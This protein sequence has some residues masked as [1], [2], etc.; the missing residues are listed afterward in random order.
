V[1]RGLL[2]PFLFVRPEDDALNSIFRWYCTEAKL[3]SVLQFVGELLD[4]ADHERFLVMTRDPDDDVISLP[5]G[6]LAFVLDTLAFLHDEANPD[7]LLSDMQELQLG[8]ADYLLISEPTDAELADDPLAERWDLSHGGVPGLNAHYG[9]PAWRRS[10]IGAFTLKALI[11]T[12]PSRTDADRLYQYLVSTITSP[13]VGS[14]PVVILRS[15]HSLLKST[16]FGADLMPWADMLVSMDGQ[17]AALDI[18]GALLQALGA[19]PIELCPLPILP[20]H[21]RTFVK[22]AMETTKAPSAYG[23]KQLMRFLSKG[24]VE[25]SDVM[26]ALLSDVRMDHVALLLA[27]DDM[28]NAV[29]LAAPTSMAEAR[30][31]CKR[32]SEL[33]ENLILQ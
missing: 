26:T 20:N 24:F 27:L 11:D 16:V 7:A 19:L 5:L 33:K 6:D 9:S 8:L 23:L 29:N 21:T 18:A 13:E 30:R 14:P 28:A 10:F 17:T 22:V 31:V 2:R 25:S 3:L 12:A 15:L 32:A 4:D 1:L